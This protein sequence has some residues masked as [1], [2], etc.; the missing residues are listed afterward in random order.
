MRGMSGLI[1]LLPITTIGF[2]AFVGTA[3]YGAIFQDWTAWLL[4]AIALPGIPFVW[5]GLMLALMDVTK[6]PNDHL[7]DEA[8][9]I[10]TAAI[11]ILN[12]FIF[13]PYFFI[14][15]R[16]NPPIPEPAMGSG[17]GDSSQASEGEPTTLDHSQQSATN[18]GE[19][20]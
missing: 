14:V 8:K 1:W 17:T 5:L 4:M 16:N 18:Q 9:M 10:W 2:F 20:T 3:L 13:I 15:V 12:V 7:S 6:R 11:C 19:S